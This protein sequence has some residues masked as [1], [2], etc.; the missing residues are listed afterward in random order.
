[1]S[2][3]FD[4]LS[5]P[6]QPWL[7]CPPGSWCHPFADRLAVSIINDRTR[8]LYYGEGHR[9]GVGPPGSTSTV[10]GIVLAPS[11]ELLCAYPQDG[12]SMHPD[13]ACPPGVSRTACAPGC[14]RRGEECAG[15]QIWSCSFPPERLREALE[16]QEADAGMRQRNNEMV[17]DAASYASLLPFAVEAFFYTATSAPRE[18]HAAR[19]A[20][21]AFARRF[22]EDARFSRSYDA[23]DFAPLLELDLEKGGR[24]PW[25]VPRR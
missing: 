7:P 15:G 5:D 25:S 17:I 21:D 3:E 6:E 4:E 9:F 2:V 24:R 11:V 19:R 1:M 18:V 12:N 16:A 10:G 23:G 22:S 13:K 8:L 14:S 20:R